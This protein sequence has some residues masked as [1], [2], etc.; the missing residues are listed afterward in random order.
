MSIFK[1][2]KDLN[3]KTFYFNFKYL[4]YKQA[5]KLPIY[6][7]KNVFIRK[8]TGRIIIEGEITRKM[9]TIGY[10]CVSVFDEKYSRAI[11]HVT[12]EVIFKGGAKIGHGSKIS[13]VGKGKLI[14]GK[15]LVI[16][17]ESTIICVKRVEFGDDCLLSWD[18][19]IMDTDLHKIKDVEGKVINKPKEILI[20]TKVWISCRNLILKGSVIPDHSIIAANSLVNKPLQGTHQVFAG[21]PVKAI[22]SQVT[23]E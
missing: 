9:I 1:K 19:L 15:N 12:G 7:S 16:T 20:G 13:V 3:Y 5:I 18:I 17:A 11:W 8:M 10:P 21:N 23:W 14:L 2:F 6:L 4:P 22:K